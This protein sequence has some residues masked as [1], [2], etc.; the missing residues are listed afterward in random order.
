M[1]DNETPSSSTA[2]AAG[3]QQ[4]DRRVCAGI[5]RRFAHAV[6]AGWEAQTYLQSLVKSM[7]TD[8]CS[9]IADADPRMAGR[10]LTITGPVGIGKTWLACAMLAEL[11]ERTTL[12]VGYAH[13]PGALPELRASETGHSQEGWRIL[14]RLKRL[15]VL[16]LDD[17]D[18]YGDF[19][20][21]APLLRHVID[22]RYANLL[23]TVVCISSPHELEVAQ[24]GEAV[25]DRLAGMNWRAPMDGISRRLGPAARL[26]GAGRSSVVRRV[27]TGGS[28]RGVVA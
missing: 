23:P 24:M 7:A 20:V 15:D 8:W 1:T 26:L 25:V 16:V 27:D 28:D 14:E 3:A 19:E 5:P 18:L 13:W 12:A 9:A 2:K 11:I 4:T 21:D 22:W 6:L 17:P 10:G